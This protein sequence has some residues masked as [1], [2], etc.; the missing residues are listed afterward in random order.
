MGS[1]DRLIPGSNEAEV[2]WLAL[3]EESVDNEDPLN[4]DSIAV[5][6]SSLEPV[7]GIADRLILGSTAP[8]VNTWE[9]LLV[10]PWAGRIRDSAGPLFPVDSGALACDSVDH[11]IPGNNSMSLES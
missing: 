8:V 3:D 1:E 9:L 10:Q 6:E 7:V 11:S 5:R 2:A 4:L